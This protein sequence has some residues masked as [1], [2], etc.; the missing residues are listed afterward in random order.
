VRTAGEHHADTADNGEEVC[1]GVP[2]RLSDCRAF[3]HWHSLQVH[4]GPQPQTSP[5]WHAAAGRGAV[6]W[7]PQV[8]S[9][10][11]QVAQASTFDW[12]DM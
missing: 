1:L 10:P 12:V 3:A 4:V 9:E 8:H 2:S 5:H 6:L 11:V 7:Q